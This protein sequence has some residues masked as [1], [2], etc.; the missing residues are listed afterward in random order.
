ML[1][2]GSEEY[3]LLKALGAYAGGQL[4]VKQ[5]DDYPTA[6]AA[7]AGEVD[8]A[9]AAAAKFALELDPGAEGGR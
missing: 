8:A 9:H 1:E 2:T 7:V 5:L 6:E 3:L 4:G